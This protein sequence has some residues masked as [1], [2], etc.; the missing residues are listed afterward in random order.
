[1]KKP[2]A[3]PLALSLCLL[4]LAAGSVSAADEM[5]KSAK[6]GTYLIELKHTSEQC[7]DKLD[8]MSAEAPK[9]LEKIQ[10]G[11]LSGDHTGYWIV[12]AP[13]EKAAR[14]M[15]PALLRDEAHVVGLNTFTVE[16]IKSFHQKR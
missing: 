12:S 14:E 16:Q 9:L 15:L 5:N 8:Q 4:I 1:M 6:K 10:W 7:L 11:C 3:L 2:S 13:S